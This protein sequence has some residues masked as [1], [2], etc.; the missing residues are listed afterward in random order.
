MPVS[1]HM[2]ASLPLT[3]RSCKCRNASNF[4]CSHLD[5][6]TFL[7]EKLQTSA[8][9]AGKEG[10]KGFL[11]LREGDGGKGQGAERGEGK[12]RGKGQRQGLMGILLQGLEGGRR[13]WLT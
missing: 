2:F 13:P 11:P 7:R 5:L 9:G 12:R 10:I 6:K 8:L 3:L 4:T 1:G